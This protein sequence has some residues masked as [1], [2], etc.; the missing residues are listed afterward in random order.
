MD[1]FCNVFKG[2]A[3]GAGCI[4][5]G[6]SSGVLCV[7]FGIYEKIL[8]SFLYFFKDIKSNVKFLL[9]LFLGIS[10]GVFIFSNFLQFFFTVFPLQINSIF[11]G[12]IVGTLPSLIKTLQLK[13]DSKSTNIF[14]CFFVFL[15]CFFIGITS[16]ILENVLPN[17]TASNISFIYLV[18]SG[19]LMS[20]GIVV[21]GV[22]S[23]IILMLLG[24][25]PIYLNSISD[26]SFNILIPM[27]IGLVLGGFIFMKLIKIL[28]DKFHNIAFSGIIGFS[29][30]SLFI[31]LP[32][33]NSIIEFLIVLFCMFFGFLISSLFEK[34]NLEE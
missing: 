15:L 16:V 4:L 2:I 19:F 22:S 12:L 34:N 20:I 8:N 27:G 10:I 17:Y 11:I 24:I 29:V 23:T 6:I 32:S 26:L 31:I 7:I 25:Y 30:G 33:F 5:P 3:L 28:L 9:P 18:I 1:F 13:K 14:S 21:P